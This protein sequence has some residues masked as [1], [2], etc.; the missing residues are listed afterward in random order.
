MIPASKNRFS[1][2]F[3]DQLISFCI[4]VNGIGFNRSFRFA[5]STLPQNAHAKI[6][7]PKNVSAYSAA[8]SGVQ[9]ECTK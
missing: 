2:H 8:E 3:G 1:S 7:F 9:P 6:K 5:F 4:K